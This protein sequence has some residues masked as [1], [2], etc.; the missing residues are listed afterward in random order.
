[1]K[2]IIIGTLAILMLFGVFS[3]SGCG[4]G[5]ISN[6]L[7][8][9]FPQTPSEGNS[10]DYWDNEE[11]DDGEIVTI[12]WFVTE[13]FSWSGSSGTIVSD[14]IEQKTGCRINFT[15]AGGDSQKLTTMIAGNNLPD[16]VTTEVRDNT[17]IQLA[18]EDYIYSITD[19]SERWAPNFMKTYSREIQTFFAA[20]DGDLYGCPQLFYSEEDTRAYEQQGGY[21]IPNRVM[22]ARRDLVK[23]YAEKYP[24]EYN[25]ITTPD[26]FI[27]FCQKVISDSSSGYTTDTTNYSAVQVAPWQ[28]DIESE[29]ISVLKEYFAV[30][31]EDENGNLTY[32]EEQEQ[33]KE[34]LLFLN[35]LKREGL[36]AQ[37]AMTDTENV[38]ANIQN[39]RPIVTMVT[40]QNYQGYFYNY[41]KTHY[42]YDNPE[43]GSDYIPII[44]TNSAGDAPAIKSLSSTGYMYSM[45]TTK[46]DRP[47]RVI[48]LFD[49]LN[50]AEGQNLMLYGVEGVTYEWDIQPGETVGGVEYKYGKIKFVDDET[51]QDTI[52][53]GLATSAYGRLQIFT[54]RL[55]NHMTSESGFTCD[56]L[57]SYLLFNQKAAL[58]DYVY[59]AKLFTIMRDATAPNYQKMITVANNLRDLWLQ[60]VAEIVS[61]NS[62]AIAESKYEDALQDAKNMGSDSLLEFD[63][64]CFQKAKKMYNVDHVWG[65]LKENYVTP[66]I[67]FTG[68]ETYKLEIPRAVWNY[69]M[70]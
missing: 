42:N 38:G 24:E 63:N 50:S 23:W 49:Y 17:R 35:R 69:V 52:A 39:G 5:A 53:N 11:Y 64:Q 45:I 43:N 4:N 27:E 30:P 16:V 32:P 61:A 21:I 18:E 54:N 34:A 13:S 37:S 20:S 59:D 19:L 44:I 41:N 9:Q 58:T 48:K 33:F 55:Y 28:D 57:D 40:P 31:L 10:W 62:A 15:S 26:G 8:T 1:M 2:K 47:D 7:P 14:M 60:R 3:A 67:V 56:S 70:G 65:P 29:T 66:E 12:D 25:Y 68:N 46:C 36:V 22:C 6:E 51:V